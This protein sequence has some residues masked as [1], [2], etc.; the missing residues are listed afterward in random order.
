MNKKEPMKFIHP[1]GGIVNCWYWDGKRA[2]LDAC[3]LDWVKHW[4]RW[5]PGVI[6]IEGG[7][8]VTHRT[9]PVWIVQQANGQGAYPVAIPL[10]ETQFKR[11][12][13]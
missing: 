6:I 1:Q 11:E 7:S 8:T 12:T 13:S 4:V 5:S 9:K 2:S 10:F 3:K